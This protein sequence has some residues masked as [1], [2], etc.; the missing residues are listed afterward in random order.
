MEYS[1]NFCVMGVPQSADCVFRT[2]VPKQKYQK[3]STQKEE[4]GGKLPLTNR[5][6]DGIPKTVKMTNTAVGLSRL[7]ADLSSFAVAA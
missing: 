3:F 5:H 4:M 7:C 1:A 2:F 6:F